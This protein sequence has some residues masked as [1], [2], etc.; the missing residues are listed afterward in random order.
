[1]DT[2][3]KRAGYAVF[4]VGAGVFVIATVL[5]SFIEFRPGHW[6]NVFEGLFYGWPLEFFRD[7]F[8]YSGRE[9]RPFVLGG[10]IIAAIGCL[11]SVAYD[12]TV[13]R[14]AHWIKAGNR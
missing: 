10:L 12:S 4:V 13:G 5:F 7:L 6:G 9:Y 2:P 1:M 11:F 8:G 3:V 14:L